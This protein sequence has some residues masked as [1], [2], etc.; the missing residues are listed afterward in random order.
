MQRNVVWEAGDGVSTEHLTVEFD[1]INA[2]GVV[3]GIRDEKPF[4][5]RYRVE[6]DG[7]GAVRRIET[8]PL[9][10]GSGIEL[11]H[12]GD[13]NWTKDGTRALELAGCRDVDISATPFTNTIPIRRL[14]LGS[15]ESETI[16]VVYLDVPSMTATPV[17]QR[18]TCLEPLGSSG[19]MYRYESLKSGFTADLPVDSDGVVVNYPGVFRRMFP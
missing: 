15:G 3:V 17:E 8:D 5:I 4:R 13:G 1:H 18:Y 2:D 14:G 6:C 19:G 11:D 12:D 16:S 9:G 10:T 7:S